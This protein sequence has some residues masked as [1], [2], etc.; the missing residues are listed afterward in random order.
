MTDDNCDYI[1]E[2]YDFAN[3]TRWELNYGMRRVNKDSRQKEK[4]MMLFAIN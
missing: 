3:I 1:R 2:L 4:Q